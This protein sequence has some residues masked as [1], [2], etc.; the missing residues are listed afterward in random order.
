MEIKKIAFIGLGVMGRP[1][2]LRLAKAGYELVV[3]DINPQAM[4]EFKAYKNCRLAKSPADAAQN[5]SYVFTMLPDSDFIDEALFGMN[6]AATSMPKNALL[7]EMSTSNA[8]RFMKLV[9]R[10]ANMGLRAIDAPMGRT[11]ADAE[12]GDLL[13]LVGADEVILNEVKPLLENF[14]KDIM[15]IGPVGYALKLK[16]INNYMSMVSMVLTAETLLFASKLGLDRDTTVKVLQNTV[17]GRGQIN[18]NF[19]K[20]VLAGDITP[21]FPL[22]LGLKDISLAI[23][24]AKSEGVPL[25]L[26]GVSREL[27]SLAKPWGR[28]QQDCTAMLLLLEDIS[29][30]S[31]PSK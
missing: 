6:G 2:A 29:N 26:G 1:M 20:K 13:V 3:Y 11:P 14:G 31:S 12:K 23:E 21:D 7:I 5:A 27:F 17:A 22:S 18:I 24:L 19:P 25:F 9:E 10:L 30:A 16:L 15:H 8:A 4:T 28:S